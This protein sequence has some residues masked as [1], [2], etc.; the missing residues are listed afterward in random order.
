MLTA[1]LILSQPPH[2]ALA[3]LRVK[4]RTDNEWL[5]RAVLALEPHTGDEYLR[6]F[7]RQLRAGKTLTV[8]QLQVARYRTS[9][10]ARRLLYIARGK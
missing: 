2:D 9:R 1:S 6:S 5:T 3:L 10:L 4:L 8:R 7:A